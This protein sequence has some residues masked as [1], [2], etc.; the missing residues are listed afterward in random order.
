[1]TDS[2]ILPLRTAKQPLPWLHPGGDCGICCL[3]GLLQTDVQSMYDWIFKNC[4]TMEGHGVSMSYEKFHLSGV[5]MKWVVD[6]LRSHELVD[7]FI[8][9]VP[10]WRTHDLTA[11]YGCPSWQMSCE[12]FSYVRMAVDAG[13]YGLAMVCHKKN[14]PL[15]CPDHWV[16]VCG[17]REREADVVR[18]GRRMGGVIR[19]EILISNSSTRAPALP[20]EWVDAG[21]FL[22]QWGG[23]NLLL[24]RPCGSLPLASP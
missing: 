3:A 17:A 11:Y 22:Q 23:Y 15:A 1:M 9:D 6:I 4:R 13:Y 12:W 7:R 16:L 18:D 21:D 24:T 20:E 2:V 8:D 19:H 10:Y 5:E 14:G